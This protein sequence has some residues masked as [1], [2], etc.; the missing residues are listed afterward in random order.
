MC[1]SDTDGPTP[2][3]HKWLFVKKLWLCNHVKD[4]CNILSHKRT[5]PDGM[6]IMMNFEINGQSPITHKLFPLYA[7]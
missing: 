2:L 1:P 6:L 7:I 4:S 3:P 5:S